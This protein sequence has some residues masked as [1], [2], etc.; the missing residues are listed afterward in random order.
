MCF[1]G[2]VGAIGAW[3]TIRTGILIDLARLVSVT[4]SRFAFVATLITSL[5]LGGIMGGGVLLGINHYLGNTDPA[6]NIADLVAGMF[7]GGLG[8]LIS[9]WIVITLLNILI[10]W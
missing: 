10:N 1:G 3:T 5:M 7:F 8:G 4:S 6:E 2:A 9:G